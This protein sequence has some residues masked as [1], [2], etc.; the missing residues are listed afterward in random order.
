MSMIFQAADSL[1][2]SLHISSYDLIFGQFKSFNFP[3]S[4]NWDFFLNFSNGFRNVLFFFVQINR[5]ITF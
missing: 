4:G 2:T 3:D 1:L 5:L